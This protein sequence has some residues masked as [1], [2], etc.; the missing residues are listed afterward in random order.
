MEEK[1]ILVDGEAMSASIFDFGLFF[2]HNA[3]EQIKN[4]LGPYFYLPK[5]ESHLEARLWN[6]IFNAAQSMLNIP[7]GTIR[8]TV[9]I[10]TILA[11]FE[12]D[13]IIYELR[14]HSSGLNCGRWDYIFSFIKKFRQYPEYV[15]PDRSDVS[16]TVPFMSAYVKLLIK[17]CHRRGVHAMGGMSAH[18]PIKS[19]AELNE[20]AMT[21]VRN[22][23]LREVT[24]GHDGTWVAHPDLVKIAI[25]IFDKHMP[26]PNQLN[27]QSDVQVTQTDLLD[28]N[29]EGSITEAGIRDN[30]QVG[31]EY[32]ESWIRGVGC[33][34]IH[35]LMEDA[36]TAE[37]SRSQ[38][39]QWARHQSVTKEGIKVT[40]DY[41][42]RILDEEIEKIRKALGPKYDSS[43]YDVAKMA[44]ATNITGQKYDDFLTTLL[45]DK[46]TTISSKPRL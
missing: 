23:K 29:F 15:L 33:V 11:A 20:A 21:K 26:E 2:Y 10:E 32:M 18:I 37:I 41:T 1:H 34:P 35:N 19:N 8:A 36:A 31:L 7:R 43:K 30:I 28:I 16:M 38:L 27:V 3:K 5:M 45:Y 44:F 9:L 25:E 42:L 13:E 17:T 46:I 22:D 14:E 12:M 40:G 6:N 24:A 39:W 4:G